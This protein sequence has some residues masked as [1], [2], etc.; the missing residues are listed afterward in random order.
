MSYLDIQLLGDF[1]LTHNGRFLT[2]FNSARLQ[3]LLVYLLL[4][5]TAPQPRQHIAFL[6]WPDSTE[7]QA[8]TNLRTLYTRLRQKL[9]SADLFLH[10]DGQTIQWLLDASF[11]LDVAEFETAVSS[12]H[13][14]TDWQ[15]AVSH[16][17]GPL[18]PGWYQ[19][20]LEPERERLQQ[21]FLQAN[22]T[23]L[24]LLEDQRRYPDA[25][26]T[27]HYLL[28]FDPLH[29]ATYRRLMRVQ[30]LNGEK[31]DAVRTYHT[32]ATLLEKE[33][34][35]T[36][37]SA[38]RTLYKQLIEVGIDPE[39]M[40]TSKPET[41]VPP[42]IGRDDEWNQLKRVWQTAVRGRA[43][44]IL[45]SGE[46]GIGKSR[47]AAELRQW[48]QRQ[49][50]DTVTTRSYEA[51]G[52]LTYA[53]LLA[54]LRTPVLQTAW[55][56]LDD[57]TL[58][59]LTRL[60]PELLVERLDLPAPTPLT[61][62]WQRQRL[63][64]AL[65]QAMLARGRP[66]LLHIDDLQWCDAETMQ[67]LHFLSRTNPKAPVLIVGTFRP[68]EIDTNHPLTTLQL[69]LRQS[70]QLN[71]LELA[72]L[73]AA[74]TAVLAT[75][76]TNHPLE[77]A[78]TDRLFQETEG[79]PLFII[80]MMR[81]GL[82]QSHK[83]PPTI[84]AMIQ[85]RF[86]HLTPQARD[87]MAQASVIGR[88]F[89]YK[90]LSQT[91][92]M[93]EDSLVTRLDELWR[94]RIVREHGGTEYDF[95]HDKFREVAYDDLSQARRRLLH[96]RVAQSLEALH[97][98][99]LSA[100]S[101]EIAAHY[102]MANMAA[103]AIP[104][105]QRA[106]HAAEQLYAHAEAITTI[107][108]ALGLLPTLPD[109]TPIP[110]R[111]ETTAQLH[112]NLGDLLHFT[113][114]YEEAQQAYEAALTAI[115]STTNSH[116]IW[117]CRLHRKIGSA[118][119]SQHQ[120]DAALHQFAQAKT[121]LGTEALVPENSWWQEWIALQQE[122]KHLFYWLNRWSEIA[123]ILEE[124][125]PI[126]AQH[127][128]P[129]QRAL[130]FDPNMY[131][132]RDRFVISDEVLAATREWLTVNLELDDPVRH[133]SA[134]FMMGFVLLWHGDLS[135]AEMEMGAALAATTITGDVNLRARCLTYLTISARKQGQIDQVRTL[136][137]Q[138]MAAAEEAAM[139]EYVATARANFAWAAWRE[140]AY[141]Q[142][143]A[144]GMAAQALWHTLP[145]GHASCAFQWTALFPLIAI[146]LTARNLDE[147]VIYAQALLDPAAQKLPPGLTAVLENAI[148]AHQH[149]QSTQTTRL[150][151]QAI[152]L[153]E[154]LHYL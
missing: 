143:R 75:H 133:A 101:R 69:S 58:T 148:T 140:E 78:E 123:D 153:A 86:A 96:Q 11:S 28:R 29:E 19:E 81:A 104:Y 6:F 3:S 134:H 4:H 107:R 44:M 82:P 111:Q 8:L 12:A 120:F 128:T 113:A 10:S 68:E 76:L 1:R 65:A 80:E 146:S 52:E 18:L 84:Q 34:G 17:H 61:Q 126:L 91:S 117:H 40:A 142:T 119:L 60:L 151:G 152:A 27:A 103:K 25:I 137:A 122:R 100:Y 110:W 130:F 105:Y 90:L 66:L 102:E 9:P 106:A 21:R 53:P 15:T 132:R 16:Y 5:R 125:R 79:N 136:A 50:I 26:Q 95:S 39:P 48:A 62:S 129:M 149:T 56:K 85:S 127:G 45:I 23:L 154:Q 97:P 33:L 42:L 135:E 73:L 150:L 144:H 147:A 67:W 55:K 63:F 41:A 71:E 13:T 141:P 37:D 2:D 116:P 83:L 72:P 121:A 115:A 88:A 112:E 32:C 131:L 24:R 47:L 22:E 54:W 92:G 114:H 57:V 74:E 51:E 49:G 139:P 46:A 98:A 108:R 124:S 94:R 109:T 99:N 118:C 36:P 70:R 38:T 31:A 20:W 59:E 14:V 138:S 87:L 35:V 93:D 64:T 145:P 89:D 43:S 7:T 77:L 30:A